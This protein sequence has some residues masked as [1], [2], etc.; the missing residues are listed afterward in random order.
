M[1]AP[2]TLGDMMPTCMRPAPAGEGSSADMPNAPRRRYKQTGIASQL[3][4][5]PKQI[6][7]IDSLR[8]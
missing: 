8:G 3:T 5:T 1:P 4:F 6:A 7:P 2:V